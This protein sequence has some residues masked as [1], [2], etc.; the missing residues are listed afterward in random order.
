[1]QANA[2]VDSPFCFFPAGGQDLSI[3]N[4]G[5]YIY[6]L[7]ID[8]DFIAQNPTIVF[9][10]VSS[11]E[12]VYPSEGSGC[13]YTQRTERQMG[14]YHA[15]DADGI[16]DYLVT[17]Y[18]FFYRG[19]PPSN[20]RCARTSENRW[21]LTNEPPT[22]VDGLPS[23]PVLDAVWH[24]S[25][26][27]CAARLNGPTLGVESARIVAGKYRPIQIKLTRPEHGVAEQR[28]S[29]EL[30]PTGPQRG[31]LTCNPR[32]DSQGSLQCGYW[33]PS[34]P[35]VDRIRAVWHHEN[36]D[37]QAAEGTI[38]VTPPSVVVGFFNGVWNTEEQAQD[39]LQAIEVLVG[40]NHG[41]T[42]LRYEKFYN[43]TGNA[44]GNTALQDIAEVFIQ[45]GH[46]LDGVLVSR[47]EVYWELLSGPVRQEG[48]LTQRLLSGLQA[49]GTALSNLIDALTSSAL[50]G[51]IKGLAQFMSQPPTAADTEAPLAKLR[52]LADE[53]ND[54]VLVAHS[55]GNLFVNLAY[56]GL[57]GYNQKVKTAVVHVAPA[58]PTLRGAHV[59]ADIDAVIN[60]LRNF[61]S[62]TVPNINIWLTGWGGDPSGHTFAGTYLDGAR[63]ARTALNAATTSPRA[64]L[65]Q[66]MIDALEQVAPQSP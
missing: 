33:A 26:P 61:G 17:F 64:H 23:D 25:T 20:P 5:P 19:Y 38:T 10:S 58:S 52:D 51:F 43:Q 9:D 41:T 42:E 57:R 30:M 44:N 46:E 48:S 49:G 65:K 11:E 35:T 31:Y 63:E 16:F 6:I 13:G 45:R 3:R 50:A 2:G 18:S 54:F 28:V 59:L 32:T 40:P 36:K 22:R 53:G 60:G 15:A 21:E 37:R 55:Q 4:A 8:D 29:V 66:M 1:M 14:P 34:I 39:G 56:D 12:V 27:V 47:W 24:G 7:K 62:W